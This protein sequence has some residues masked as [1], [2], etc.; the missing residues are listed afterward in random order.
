VKSNYPPNTPA[1]N[2][3]RRGIIAIAATTTLVPKLRGPVEY[4]HRYEIVTV[5]SV[6]RGGWV[7]RYRTAWGSEID[8]RRFKLGNRPTIILASDVDTTAAEAVAKAHHWPGH[9]GQPQAFE[10]L[11]AVREA[12]APL[13]RPADA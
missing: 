4:D 13:L 5:T 10:S 7:L 3:A 2:R 6:S 1:A 8:L 9:P 12:L 11:E